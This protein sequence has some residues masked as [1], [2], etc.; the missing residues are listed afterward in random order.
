[1]EYSSR[2][3]IVSGLPDENMHRS[4]FLRMDA[5][6][7]EDLYLSWG[8]GSETGR[9]DGVSRKFALTNIKYAFWNKP[10]FVSGD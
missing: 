3:G 6:I 8:V 2:W 5:K 7:G 9:R 10:A 1:M 4:F